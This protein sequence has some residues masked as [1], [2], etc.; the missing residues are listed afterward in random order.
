MVRIAVVP[1]LLALAGCG[2]S[3]LGT[4][5]RPAS[6][7]DGSSIHDRRPVAAPPRRPDPS[8]P[9]PAWVHTE[10]GSRWLAFG[11][12]CWSAAPGRGGCADMIGP[13][14]RHD[15]PLLV[16]KSGENVR[17][18]LAFTADSVDVYI[19][20]GSHSVLRRRNT[21]AVAWPRPTRPGD[22]PPS[23]PR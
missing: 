9:P 8:A 17:F 14:Q 22:P 7:R 19:G 6:P 2:V 16:V 23:V 13:D 18:H 3:G 5:P 10:H 12:Y 1:M 21:R 20:H 4:G 11:S 15:L